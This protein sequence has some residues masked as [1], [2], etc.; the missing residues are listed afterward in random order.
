MG[1][2]Y[3]RKRICHAHHALLSSKQAGLGLI[4]DT[5]IPVVRTRKGTTTK[6]MEQEG[7]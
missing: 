6:Q 2:H 3:L 1:L 5:L 7:A 4:K